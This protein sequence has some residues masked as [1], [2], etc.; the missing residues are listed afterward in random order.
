MHEVPGDSRRRFIRTLSLAA[1][2]LLAPAVFTP[3]AAASQE[4]KQ[5]PILL[6]QKKQKTVYSVLGMHDAPRVGGSVDLDRMKNHLGAIGLKF[7]VGHLPSPQWYGAVKAFGATPIVRLDLPENRFNEVI[8][9]KQLDTV[10]EGTLVTP[11]NE[12]N[13]S[14][15]VGWK[16][17]F[18][19]EAALNDYMAFGQIVAHK[20]IPMV[21]PTSPGGN[22]EH[23]DGSPA[24]DKNGQGYD[25][26]RYFHNLME[27]HGRLGTFGKYP[28][29]VIAMHAYDFKY[30][31][32]NLPSVWD[33]LRKL[34]ETSISPVAGGIPIYI[35]EG[36]YFLADVE[37]SRINHQEIGPDIER[38]L[39]LDL[40]EVAG[41][42]LA[43]QIQSFG[44]WIYSN[45]AQILPTDHSSPRF[46]RNA[47]FEW[48][49]GQEP[50]TNSMF[51]SFLR[52]HQ[53]HRV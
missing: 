5:A 42:D 25:E 14:G 47:L 21:S 22:L 18:P 43:K 9:N 4:V 36:G 6:L 44:W 17:M 51:D 24:L 2:S 11:G 23:K 48:N 39:G 15:E 13:Q 49:K 52:Y 20:C 46:E 16:P 1:V 38:F 28:Q 37:E 40:A 10:P 19:E 35:K 53:T 3:N 34:N 45:Y 12:Y 50:K 7:V 41:E 8:I 29:A 33:R 31:N 30:H 32:P 26:E 27:E